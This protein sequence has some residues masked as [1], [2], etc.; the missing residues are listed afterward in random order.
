VDEVVRDFALKW[1]LEEHHLAEIRKEFETALETGS[2]EKKKQEVDYLNRTYAEIGFIRLGR[3]GG[4]GFGDIYT[5]LDLK[6]KEIV[7]IK[8]IDLESAK[9]DVF[10]IQKE[11]RVL[12]DVQKCPQLVGYRGSKM[13]ETELWI[14][15]EYVKGGSV[16]DMIKAK[17]P[18]PEEHIAVITRE[19][20]LALIY[21]S[22]ENRIHRDIKG[23]NILIQEDGQP[24]LADLGAIGQLTH[25]SPQTG[26]M[27]GSPYWMAPEVMAGKYDGKADVWSLG[28][29]CIEMAKGE[30]P[31]RHLPPLKVI[32]AMMKNPAPTLDPTFSEDFQDFISCCLKKDPTERLGIKELIKHPFITQA[33]PIRILSTVKSLEAEPMSG[34][35]PDEHKDEAQME[36]QPDSAIATQK[37]DDFSFND[38]EH[39]SV[40][41]PEPEEKNLSS[42]LVSH[43]VLEQIPRQKP[44][45][46]LDEDHVRAEDDAFSFA[47]HSARQMPSPGDL[48]RK[49]ETQGSISSSGG[50]T[51]NRVA[52]ASVRPIVEESTRDF[53]MRNSIIEDPPI[54][55]AKSCCIML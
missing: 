49:S 8:V 39:H 4:G 23:A 40:K 33:G 24:K 30:P 7:A 28:I 14:I 36:T 27:I 18:F 6:T 55:N 11:T 37:E 48:R 21:L 31:L 20:L 43:A 5:G 38:P 3:L 35:V 9:D 22:R 29:T 34:I 51:F 42:A 44:E 47:D 46:T 17:G 19:I 15:M 45:A 12:S 50:T 53:E 32:M 13:H 1:G 10:S 41:E 25:T 16:Y 52:E 26:T 54:A 2:D